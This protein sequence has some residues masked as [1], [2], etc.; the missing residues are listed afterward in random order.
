MVF[1]EL[2]SLVQMARFATEKIPPYRETNR[3]SN[4]SPDMVT[5][6]ESGDSNDSTPEYDGDENA[7]L[8]S[9]GVVATINSGKRDIARE[10]SRTTKPIQTNPGNTIHNSGIIDPM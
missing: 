8:H 9:Q 2:E 1:S 3:T 10:E 5:P 6:N 4:D 7:V